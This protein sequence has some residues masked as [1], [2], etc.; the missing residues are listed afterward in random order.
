MADLI[1]PDSSPTSLLF[2]DHATALGGAEHSLLMILERLDRRRW[3]PH[4]A[5]RA[6][7]LAERAA[8]LGVPIHLTPQP[9]LRRSP[10]ALPALRRGVRSLAGVAREVDAALLIANTVRAAFYAAPAAHVVRIPFVWY[11]RDFWLGQSQPRLLWADRLAKALL[12]AASA[13]VIANS[14]ATLRRHPLQHKIV[15]IPNGIQVQ[16]YDPALDGVP[17]RQAYGIPAA[18]PLLG[19]LGRLSP[20]KGQDRFLGILEQVL[21]REPEVWGVIVGGPLF[22]QK[23]YEASLHRLSI[24]LGVAE[25]VVFTGQL[26]DPRPALAALDVF[27]QPGDPE[28]FGLVNVEAMAMAKP[29][30]AFAHGALPEIVVHGETGL[31]VPPGDEHAL[32]EAA[33]SLLRDPAL[34]ARMGAAGRRR[35]TQQYAIERT[36]AEVEALLAQLVPG[37]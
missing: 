20:I 18:A 25:R 7:S 30:V 23:E 33:C 17:F 3:A 21:A 5:C 11:R 12:G 31:L 10:S 15:V 1:L 34:R 22:E 24:E 2:V 35:V 27:V 6:G 28:A 14:Q 29:V 13:R 26:D 36:V 19:M 37:A 32:A 8:A 9:Q 4:L 16:R